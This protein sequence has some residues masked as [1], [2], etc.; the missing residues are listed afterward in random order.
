MTTIAA[1]R[2]G[3][4]TRLE[5]IA[6]LRVY[7]EI[8]T[9]VSVTGNA[10]AAVITLAEVS[11]DDVMG[12]Q[13]DSLTFTI[14]LIVAAI[15]DRTAVAKLDSYLDPTHPS[16][17]SVRSAVNGSLGGAVAFATVTSATGPSAVTVGT[18]AEAAE[19]LGADFTVEVK[20]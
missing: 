3:L 16:A 6:S 12:N 20:L 1:V 17:T 18:G 8:P 7:D 10:S 13:G 9:G 14:T 19:Y 5:T 4:Q 11:Y 2:A 15:S